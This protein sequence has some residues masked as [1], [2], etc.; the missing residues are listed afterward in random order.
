[1]GLLCKLYAAVIAKSG[2]SDQVIWVKK[3][4]LI[5]TSTLTR[6]PPRYCG[7]GLAKDDGTIRRKL[8]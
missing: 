8:V 2:I 3:V 6:R 7:R 1:M 4:I 5:K